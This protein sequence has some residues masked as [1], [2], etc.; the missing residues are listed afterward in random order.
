MDD[1]DSD[2]EAFKDERLNN[3]EEAGVKD[4]EPQDRGNSGQMWKCDQEVSFPCLLLKH[5]SILI[6]RNLN[7]CTELLH[8]EHDKEKE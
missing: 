2:K 7:G 1:D 5:V 6:S 4:E 8:E 3:K